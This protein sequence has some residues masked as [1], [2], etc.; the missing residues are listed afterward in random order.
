MNAPAQD[1]S[2]FET[3]W[4]MAGLGGVNREEWTVYVPKG[5]VPRT[6]RQFSLFWYSD[7]IRRAI[8]GRGFKNA[9]ELGC[10]RGTAGL[11]LNTY[12]GLDVT[13]VDLSEDALDL[14]RRNFAHHGGTG[15]FVA[16][17]VRHLPFPDGAFDVACS[18]GLLEHFQDY[19]EVMAET[20]R[21]LRPGGLMVSLNIPGKRSVQSLNAVYKRLIR[22]FR[23]TPPKKDYYRNNDTAEQ[24]AAH[25]AAAG[26]VDLTITHVNPFP[27]FVP[28]YLPLDSALTYLDRGVARV[29]R[30]WREYPLETG[31]RLAQAHFLVGRKP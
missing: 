1:N 3:K 28:V 27:L 26:F 9:I 14:S 15:T 30:L 18:I 31:P 16:A 24:Y 7:F 12:D 21:V 5:G 13:L 25:A 8:R 11:Y 29:R 4:K 20:L 6:Q 22:P 19:R 23:T 2:A 17:D 10:G